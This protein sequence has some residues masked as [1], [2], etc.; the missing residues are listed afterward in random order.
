MSAFKCWN[1]VIIMKP[2]LAHVTFFLVMKI[3][4]LNVTIN[5]RFLKKLKVKH[6]RKSFHFT[7]S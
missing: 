2:F 3:Y 5:L 6:K 1:E 7:F 4:P